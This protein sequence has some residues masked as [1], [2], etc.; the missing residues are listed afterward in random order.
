MTNLLTTSQAC[1]T[2]N[3]S[4]A[5]LY[6]YIAAGRITPIRL[7][8]RAVR[9]DPAELRRFVVASTA[10]TD[11]AVI[12]AAMTLIAEEQAEEQRPLCPKCGRRRVNRGGSLCTWCVEQHEVQLLHKRNWW[13][14][15]GNDWRRER[16][17]T[18]DA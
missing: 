18:A 8:N 2:L 17:A 15:H 5:T 3:I 12:V 6:R 13:D 10:W 11:P 9:Y 14:E 16:K 4:R 1:A 7:S